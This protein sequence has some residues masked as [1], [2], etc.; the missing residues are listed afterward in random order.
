MPAKTG[1]LEIPVSYHGVFIVVVLNHDNLTY[2]LTPGSDFIVSDDMD[3]AQKREF[4]E[5]HLR[6]AGYDLDGYRYDG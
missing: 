5:S 4:V 1:R 6:K 3:V 2:Y